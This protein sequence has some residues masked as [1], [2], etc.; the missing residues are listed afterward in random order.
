MRANTEKIGGSTIGLDGR[1]RLGGGVTKKRATLLLLQ[2]E[3]C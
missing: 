2:L 1:E 3:S